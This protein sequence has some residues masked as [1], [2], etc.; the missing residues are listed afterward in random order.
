M[1]IRGK[2]FVEFIGEGDPVD[3]LRIRNVADDFALVG[4]DHD[5][6]SAARD[7]QA[8][9]GRIH[10]ETVPAARAAEFHFL[11]SMIAGGVTG[12]G[13]SADAGRSQQG[14]HKKRARSASNFL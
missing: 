8:M 9:C 6:V 3:A 2:T 1:A 4:I 5:D 7:E 10:F 11:D 12:L 13:S 14:Q